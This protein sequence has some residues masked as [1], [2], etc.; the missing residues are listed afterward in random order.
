[1]L[2]DKQ[3]AMA[4]GTE[5]RSFWA[6]LGNAIWLVVGIPVAWVY[7]GLAGILAF[8]LISVGLSL[9]RFAAAGF[10]L[11]FTLSLPFFG[12]AAYLI[13]NWF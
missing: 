4:Q 7:G 11:A 9:L 5:R 8:F 3:I 1:M 13:I 10:P 2:T 12:G 6:L